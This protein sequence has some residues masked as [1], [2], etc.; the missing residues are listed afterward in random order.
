VTKVVDVQRG[1]VVVVF[2]YP[3]GWLPP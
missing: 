3:G 1:D 2:E